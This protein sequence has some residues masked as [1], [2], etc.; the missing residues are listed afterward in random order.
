M[1]FIAVN[2][3][4]MVLFG[5]D[6]FWAMRDGGRIPESSLL[7]LSALGPFGAFLGMV[8]FRHKIRKPKFLLVPLFLII[9]LVLLYYFQVL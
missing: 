2:L 3:I 4:S 6:K 7:M 1:V 5:L 9:Q 8:L